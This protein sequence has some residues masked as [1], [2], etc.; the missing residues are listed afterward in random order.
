[1]NW[2][3]Y[4]GSNDNEP[5]FFFFAAGISTQDKGIGKQ[6]NDLLGYFLICD[7]ALREVKNVKRFLPLSM[8]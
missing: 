8:D 6:W 7:R 1:M 4:F 2:I 5:D 3:Y